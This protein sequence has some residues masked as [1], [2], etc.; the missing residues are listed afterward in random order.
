MVVAQEPSQ[1]EGDREQRR[2]LPDPERRFGE[3]SALGN[4]SAVALWPN[5]SANSCRPDDGRNVSMMSR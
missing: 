3:G 4:G 1:S 5:Q 2:R